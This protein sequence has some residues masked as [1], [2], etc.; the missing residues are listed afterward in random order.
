[1]WCCCC[2]VVYHIFWWIEPTSGW[3]V[4]K[5]IKR[6]G[7]S[8]TVWSLFSFCLA[9]KSFVKPLTC[10]TTVIFVI[11]SFLLTANTDQKIKLETT[12]DQHVLKVEI[13]TEVEDR[14]HLKN[15]VRDFFYCLSV[16]FCPCLF[17]LYKIFH[18]LDPMSHLTFVG[19]WNIVKYESRLHFS[20]VGSVIKKCDGF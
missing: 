14:D 9:Y 10:Y 13:K 1:M 3:D 16:S 6:N 18:E 17:I 7:P 4:E 19:V 15:Q 5:I 2:C 12:L 20:T 11:A 8:S